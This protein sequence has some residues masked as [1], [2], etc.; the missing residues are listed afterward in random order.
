VRV[1]WFSPLPPI[2]S[3][4]AAYSAEIL[5]G[6]RGEFTIDCFV[7]APPHGQHVYDAHDFVWRHRLAPY[8][9]TVYQLGNAPCHDYMWAYLAAYPGLV[10]LHDA[11]LHHARAR[12]LLA[13]GRAHDYR[14][15]F[16]FDHPD[17]VPHF[18]E[19][20]IEGLGGPIYSFW[21]MLRVVMVTAR[22]V[23]VHNPRVAT[24]LRAEYPAATIDTLR[25][26]VRASAA[27]A[28][29]AGRVRRRLS[30][31]AGAI[32]FAA[33]GKMTAEKRIGP[34]LRGFRAL[35]ALS[36]NA[37]L[38]LV[39]DAGEYPA[40]EREKFDL[41]RVRATGYVEDREIG[42]YL[43]ASD[44]CLCLRWPTALETS[45]SWLRCLAAGRATV[46]T[47]LAHLAD[48]PA[49]EPRAPLSADQARQ[50]VAMT[51]DL[52]D[53][54]RSL[55]LAMRRL[56]TDSVLRDRLARHGYDWWQRQ[57]TIE[58]MA[59]DYRRVIHAA[60]DRPAPVPTSLPAHITHDYAETARRTADRFGVEIDVLRHIGRAS[61][62]QPFR[63]SD[64][65]QP[66]VSTEK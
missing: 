5:P 41:D 25:M 61:S 4:I 60:I 8:D 17:A 26:G 46:I 14:E 53:E 10:V 29:A 37:Y 18:V 33:F 12:A 24:D 16:R 58:L 30:I 21:S 66:E 9:L 62:G 19:Y 52:L 40:L 48:V 3:G 42:A 6:L 63:L 31:P 35:L 43:A 39:G 64:V 22:M 2:R 45:A 7:E 20:A 49:M 57:H 36:V 47:N 28:D 23:A 55:L 1:A 13:Q 15:E 65:Q 34:I 32:V 38:L 51:I 11:R 54:D 56:A 50:P 27:D 44:V 59:N